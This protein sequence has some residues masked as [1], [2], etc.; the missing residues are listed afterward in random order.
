MAPF[1]KISLKA[2]S[3]VIKKGLILVPWAIVSD[4]FGKLSQVPFFWMRSENFHL[5]CK[6]SYFAFFKNELFVLSET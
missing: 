5:R 6:Q 1:Q 2:N 3:S 4:F